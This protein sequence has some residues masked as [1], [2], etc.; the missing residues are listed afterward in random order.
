MLQIVDRW[1]TVAPTP[2]FDFAYSWGSQRADQALEGSP[3]LQAV[4][5]LHNHAAGP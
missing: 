1:G 5:A 4:F 2:V 3:D